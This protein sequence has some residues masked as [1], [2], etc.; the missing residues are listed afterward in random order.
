MLN[1]ETLDD[2]VWSYEEPLAAMS[3][4]A[5]LLSFTMSES[6]LK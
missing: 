1:G 4:I 2:V 3:P 5:G 6:R